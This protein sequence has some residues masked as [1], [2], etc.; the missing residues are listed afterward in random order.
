MKEGGESSWTADAA[1]VLETDTTV[2]PGAY[3]SKLTL[4]LFEDAFTPTQ[5]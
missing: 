1:L 4:S 2:T 5:P 3:S